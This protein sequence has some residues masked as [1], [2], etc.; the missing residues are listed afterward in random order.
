MITRNASRVESIAAEKIRLNAIPCGMGE[1]LMVSDANGWIVLVNQAFR[2][3]V[4]L[5]DE[6][7]VSAITR[8]TLR[9]GLSEG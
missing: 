2:D 1:W 7:E 6:V 4:S 3:I 8:L 9:M 5:H